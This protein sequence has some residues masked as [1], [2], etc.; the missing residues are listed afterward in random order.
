MMNGPINIRLN[1]GMFITLN[2]V[3][4]LSSVLTIRVVCD[5]SLKRT[6]RVTRSGAKCSRDRGP[7]IY[8]TSQS[9]IRAAVVEVS[10]VVQVTGVLV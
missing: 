10:W 6:L 2:L 1:L 5:C 7:V 3:L 4:C 9:I 8:V